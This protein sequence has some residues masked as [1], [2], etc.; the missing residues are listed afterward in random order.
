MRPSVLRSATLVGLLGLA[1][2]ALV[3]EV[4]VRG[5]AVSPLIVA[6][7]SEV[8][9]AVGPLFLEG[10]LGTALLTT[11]GEISAA[12]A[13]AV[14]AGLPLGWLLHRHVTLGAAYENWLGAMFAAPMI[15]LYPLFLVFFG[16]SYV[17]VV[18]MGVVTGIIPII[19]H[20][21]QGLDAVPQTLVDVGLSYNLDTR[22]LFWKIMFPAAVPTIFTGIRLGIIYALVNIIG[23][24]FL[25]D[26]G[27]LGRLVS[28]TYFRYD[29]PGMYASIVFIIVVSAALFWLLSRIEIWFRPA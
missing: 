28:D 22:A 27:G 12:T 10:G 1:G 26:F 13:I 2:V 8:I 14:A 3:L 5:G 6:P 20:V 9:L 11:L 24:E 25:I 16:R 19:I 18:F 4:L 21:R 7:P 23:I 29:I 17:T 15:L